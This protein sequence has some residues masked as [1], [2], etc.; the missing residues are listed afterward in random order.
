MGGWGN[1]LIV[2]GGEG[3]G[4]GFSGG[5]PKKGITFET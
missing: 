5:G 2:A 4:Y 1:T 3:K